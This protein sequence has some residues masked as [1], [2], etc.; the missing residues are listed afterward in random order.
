MPT[1]GHFAET[2]ILRHRL[3]VLIE[4]QSGPTVP[5]AGAFMGING[6]L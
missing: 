4:T 3:S 5:C 6:I 2:W 1:F